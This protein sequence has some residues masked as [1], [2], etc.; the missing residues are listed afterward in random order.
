[1]SL[2]TQF[3]G[4]KTRTLTALYHLVKQPEISSRHS[5]VQNLLSGVGL[6]KIPKAK[7]G[8][9]VGNAW[10]PS[11]GRETPWI[12][13][14]RQ[15]AGPARV[16]AL[17]PK[18]KTTP[19]GTE[20]L[21]RVIQAAGGNVLFL[22]DE[23]L[24][25]ISRHRDLAEAFYAFL[26]NTVRAMTGTTGCAAMLSLPRSRMEMT[27]FDEQWLDRISKVVNRVA[28]DLIANDESE[29]SEVVR[30]RLFEN[31][32]RES[33]RKSVAKAYAEWCFER[34]G[35]LPPEWK[36]VDTITTDAK[37]REHLQK[38]FEAA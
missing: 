20:S 17:G 5:E 34:R 36:A 23:V 6:G 18:A 28:K 10:D 24:N 32:G 2:I 26:D 12:D 1:M 8:V 21:Q 14:A 19:P 9:F 33:T 25:F 11:E 30:R 35:Q 3:G 7:V 4:G 29:I 15:M 31:L 22:F 13:L 38:R 27:E 16:E 37:A